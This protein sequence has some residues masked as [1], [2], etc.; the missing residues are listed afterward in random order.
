MRR[1]VK[2]GGHGRGGGGAGALAPKGA[3]VGGCHFIEGLHGSGVGLA[4]GDHIGGKPH[5]L[6]VFFGHN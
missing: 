5:L 3:S 2:V 4:R 1:L 6:G